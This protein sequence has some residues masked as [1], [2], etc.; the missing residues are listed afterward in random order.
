PTSSY[1]RCRPYE[2]FAWS[3]AKLDDVIEIIPCRRRHQGVEIF[4]GLL[5]RYANRQQTC[6]GQ[7]RLD[8]LAT[9]LGVDSACKLWLGFSLTGDGP[10]V[11]NIRVSREVA[12]LPDG[13]NWFHVDWCNDLEWWYS[14]RQCQLSQ[15]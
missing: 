10:R 2:N 4:S 13:E 5:L 12:T 3:R 1:P 14:S 9:P 6:V 15:Q 7:V 11:S 8:Q